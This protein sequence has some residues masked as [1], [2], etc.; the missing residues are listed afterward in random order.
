MMRHSASDYYI[1]SC[2]LGSVQQCLVTRDCWPTGQ[3]HVLTLIKRGKKGIEGFAGNSTRAVA[4]A[5]VASMSLFVRY[6]LDTM[7]GLLAINIAVSFSP[8]G[9]P[10]LPIVAKGGRGEV[11]AMPNLK[12]QPLSELRFE[13]AGMERGIGQDLLC[14]S[15]LLLLLA[16]YSNKTTPPICIW[17]SIW[18]F[19]FPTLVPGWQLAVSI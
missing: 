5:H 4:S 10:N 7:Q 3:G 14:P 6:A 8:F 11:Q 9:A 13:Q 2:S 19:R 17:V 18:V 1:T 12:P 15:T 16:R